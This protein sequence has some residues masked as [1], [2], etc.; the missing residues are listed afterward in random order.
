MDIIDFGK[1]PKSF[2]NL[3]SLFM[4]VRDELNDEEA[5]KKGHQLIEELSKKRFEGEIPKKY[6][7]Y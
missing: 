6:E 1:K 5:V 4:L 2:I 3:N 7:N